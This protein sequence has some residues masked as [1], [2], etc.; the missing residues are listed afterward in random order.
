MIFSK[1][2][3][4]RVIN[5][6]LLISYLVPNNSDSG[7]NFRWNR[8]LPIISRA[9]INQVKMR[10]SLPKI[11]RN[12]FCKD[13]CLIFENCSYLFALL[14]W[15]QRYLLIQDTSKCNIFL[16]PSHIFP[17]DCKLIFVSNFLLHLDR[18]GNILLHL[19]CILLL[20]HHSYSQIHKSPYQLHAK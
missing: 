10:Y 16:Q 4:D 18:Y 5:I 14:A 13:H 2:W 17:N 19:M 11:M 9:I 1:H 7:M 20:A 15:N 8:G 6:F 12:P 3:Q